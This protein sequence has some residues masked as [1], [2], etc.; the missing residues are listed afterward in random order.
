MKTDGYAWPR[1]AE[2]DDH[3]RRKLKILREYFHQYLTVRCQLPQQSKFRLA[4]VD[5]FSGGGRY[6]CGSAGSPIIFIEELDRALEAINLRR[7]MQGLG[8]I[9]IECLLVFNDAL[10]S[11]TAMLASYCEPLVAAVKHKSPKLH[12]DVCYFSE[13]FEAAYPAIRDLIAKGRYRNVLYNL[14]QYGHAEVDITTLQ[15]ILRATPS[16][17]V[18]YTFAIQTLLT[19]LS[20]RDPGLL[21][22][23]LGHLGIRPTDLG[24]LEGVMTKTEWLGAAERLVFETLRTCAP[25]VSP[26]SIRNPSGWRYWMIHFANSYRARQVYNDVLHDNG[27][28]DHFGRSGLNMLAYDPEREGRLYLFEAE[29]R[30]IARTNLLS[31]IPRLVSESGDAMR[32]NEFYEAAYSATPSHKDDIHAAMLESEDLEVVTRYGGLRRKGNT[33]SIGDTLRLKAQRSFFPMLGRSGPPPLVGGAAT[34]QTD[35]VT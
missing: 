21:L 22:R 15:D 25:Y 30:A 2:L 9:E 5:G 12:L 29:D 20:G 28:L 11:V 35:S 17:E 3:S 16:T 31:D 8:A 23:Q 18:F 4:I 19:Y 14:D 13:P 6:Q 32:V 24:A 1:G 7:A 33:I 10:P 27:H 34:A 26:F